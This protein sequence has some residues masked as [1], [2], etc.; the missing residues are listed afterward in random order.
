MA[1]DGL[2]LN[3]LEESNSAADQLE[4]AINKIP[5]GKLEESFEFLDACFPKETMGRCLVDGNGKKGYG[6]RRQKHGLSQI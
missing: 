2:G 6:P 1:E 5:R 3:D 4:I